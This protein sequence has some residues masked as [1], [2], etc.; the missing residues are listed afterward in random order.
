[1][2]LARDGSLKI[3]RSRTN[4]Q[5]RCR[6]PDFFEILEVPVRVTRLAFRSRTEDSRYIVVAFN[7]SLSREI[8]IT[9]IGL[10]LA[11]KRVFKI[12]LG[13]AAF[14]CDF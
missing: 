14:Q 4:R 12:S 7:I 2:R 1:M 6:I 3:R 10:R 11:R 8:E 13:L 5:P 9:A